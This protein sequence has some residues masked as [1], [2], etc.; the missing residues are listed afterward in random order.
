MAH[1]IPCNNKRSRETFPRSVRDIEHV[2]VHTVDMFSLCSCGLSPPGCIPLTVSYFL[3]TLLSSAA[4]MTSA[5]LLY[6]QFQ[7]HD[8]ICLPCLAIY[9]LHVVLFFVLTLRWTYSGS[10]EIPR[11]QPPQSSKDSQRMSKQAN[12]NVKGDTDKERSSSDEGSRREQKMEA[13][14]GKT[15]GKA[16]KRK[17]KKDKDSN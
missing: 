4:S 6:M 1:D 12:D 2:Y 16:Q 3:A 13:V 7:V 9:F 11:S 5:Y 15:G 10:G 17:K 14:G 8:K